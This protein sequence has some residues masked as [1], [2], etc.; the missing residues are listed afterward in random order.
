[1]RLLSLFCHINSP[2]ISIHMY[3]NFN[4][5]LE[6]GS[7][8]FFFFLMD[9]RG[10]SSI[11]SLE[12]MEEEGEYEACRST[13]R[14]YLILIER[15]RLGACGHA[16]PVCC[17]QQDVQDVQSKKSLEV[18]GHFSSPLSQSV[19]GPNLGRGL[20]TGF[21]NELLSQSLSCTSDESQFL[22]LQEVDHAIE[23][24]PATSRLPFDVLSLRQLSFLK[25]A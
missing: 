13:R 21:P 19:Q 22:F 8:I 1:M 5:L 16:A 2:D 10:P 25:S 7:L 6:A 14:L 4:T 12:A 24:T 15:W 23:E 9:P 11:C 17:I 18:C 3:M 20:L